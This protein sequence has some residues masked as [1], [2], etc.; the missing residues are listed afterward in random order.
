MLVGLGYRVIGLDMLGYGASSKPESI[1]SYTYSAITSNVRA[2]VKDHFGLEKAIFLAHDWGSMFMWQLAISYPEVVDGLVSLCVPIYEAPPADF[3]LEM[4][5]NYVPQL[6]YQ[7]S[8]GKA[9][10]TK[11]DQN[12][13]GFLETFL[14]E[15]PAC[16]RKLSVTPPTV[17]IVDFYKTI[18]CNRTLAVEPKDMEFLTYQ[19]SQSGTK[20][21]TNYYRTYNINRHVAVTRNNANITQPTLYINAQKDFVT[22]LAPGSNH[23]RIRDLTER[24][25]DGGHW[26]FLT[27]KEK[28]NEYI[29]PWILEKFPP[30]AYK[31]QAILA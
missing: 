2:L 26:I 28:V 23:K 6:S 4:L 10:T 3:T 20:G 22:E 12:I 21:P 30:S 29:K 15:D 17:D 27:H 16:L 25:I 11:L 9:N 8:I 24:S 14:A 18:N 19:F 13:F 5:V 7:L 31:T 1:D